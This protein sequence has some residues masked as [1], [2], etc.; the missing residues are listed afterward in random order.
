MKARKSSMGRS[1]K[2]KIAALSGIP[3]MLLSGFLMYMTIQ[4][5]KRPITV[6]ITTANIRQGWLITPDKF[7][8]TQISRIG[9]TDN[10]LRSKEDIVGKYA[11]RNFGKQ[12]YFFSTS[13]TDNYVRTVKE[14]VRYGGVP[15]PVDNIS[16]V[17]GEIQENDFI[18]LFAITKR[19]DGDQQTYV[20]AN[21]DSLPAPEIDIYNPAELSAVRVLGIYDGAGKSVE[22]YKERVLEAEK[23]SMQALEAASAKAPSLLVVDVLPIQQQMLIYAQKAGQLQTVILPK[24]VQDEFKRQWNLVDNNGEEVDVDEKKR[25]EEENSELAKDYMERLK[26]LEEVPEVK[27]ETQK[28]I[29]NAMAEQNKEQNK[30]NGGAN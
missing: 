19:K 7:E 29:D 16:T 26:N 14:R 11:L 4:N 17:N 5:T 30:G 21:G 3:I 22:M 2:L 25:T 15:I 9:I 8:M 28:A 10:L 20:S 18:K 27:Q 12:E 13:V 24:K 1:V 6:P 23:D